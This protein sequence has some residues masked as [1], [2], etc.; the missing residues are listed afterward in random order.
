MTSLQGKTVLIAGAS[1]GIGAGFAQ[2]IAAAGAHV[3]L[4]AR[5]T[6]RIADLAAE[7]GASG[8]KALAVPLDVTDEASVITAYDQAEANFGTVNGIVANAGVGT[9]GHST[10][11]PFAGLRQVIDTNL[12]GAYLVAREG[13]RRMIAAG[14]REREDGR[15]VLIGSITAHQNHGGDAAYAATKAGLAHLG[16]Q[17]AREWIRQ[18][19]NVNTLEPGWI[20][21]EAN[22]DWFTT[23]RGQADIQGLHRRRLLDD[24]ALGDMLLY[25]LSARSRQVTGATFTIDDGQSL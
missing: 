16:R 20:A 3:V 13:A 19:I 5:R 22:A 2:L 12:I 21:S 25:L 8:G 11:V 23:E 24:D 18:G 7:I 10:D 6:D 9:G 15:I 4:G 17:F 1:S 14:S